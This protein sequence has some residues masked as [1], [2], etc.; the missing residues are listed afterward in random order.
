MKAEWRTYPAT[1]F[2]LAV[3]VLVFLL[4]QL[5]YLGQASS[6]QAVFDFG[7]MY[8]DWVKIRPSQLWRLI[9]PIF[10]H[11]GWQHFIMN[12]VTLY[13]LGHLVEKLWGSKSFLILYL[14]AGGFGN[15][16]TMFVTP[17]VLA[18]GAST[19]LFG[20]FAAVV[21][22]GYASKNPYLKQLGR[23][24]QSLLVLNLLFNL[25]M[26]D[27]SLVGHLGGLIGGALASVF[28]SLPEPVFSLKSRWLAA[29]TYLSLVVLF[30]VLFYA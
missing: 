12:S 18:A 24:Y 15:L 7:G 6:G 4:M 10:V 13:F 21:V 1:S 19:S 20:L 11:I 23:S 29:L 5:R 25:F 16:L 27:V 30:L 9:M 17:S 28:I 8:G 3:T 26:P 14:L 22:V 2:L